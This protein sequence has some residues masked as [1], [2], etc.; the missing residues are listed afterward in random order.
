MNKLGNALYTIERID[1]SA[2]RDGFLQR[3]HPLAKLLTTILYLITVVSFSNYQ[4]NGIAAMGLYLYVLFELSGLVFSQALYRLRIV[5]P[6]VMIVGIFNPFIDKTPVLQ[7]FGFTITSGMI[8][9]LSLMLKGIYSVLATYIL[10]ATTPLEHLC[11]ALRQ[12]HL[13]RMLVTVFMLIYRYI[14]VILKQASTIWQAYSL[15]AP[16]Q[17][18]VH[19]KNWGTLTGNLLLKSIDLSSTLYQSMQ[20]RGFADEFPLYRQDRFNRHDLIYLLAVTVLIVFLRFF[21]LF[22]VIGRLILGG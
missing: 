6:L 2:H 13:P 7:V 14:G 1:E 4:L 18:G 5:L 10:I 9:M 11:Y 8:S 3:I 21:P 15:R 22:E 20:L 16:G 12:L 17:K 19:Y